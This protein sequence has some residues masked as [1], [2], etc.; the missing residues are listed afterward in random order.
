MKDG[1]IMGRWKHRLKKAV[2]FLMSAVIIAGSAGSP[3]LLSVQAEDIASEDI[4][5]EGIALQDS[6]GLADKNT[7]DSGEDLVSDEATAEDESP[8]KEISDFED[9]DF[10]AGS[11]ENTVEEQTAN[12]V[13]EEELI[14][15]KTLSFE[16]LPDNDELLSAY[17][18]QLSCGETDTEIFTYGIVGDKKLTDTNEKKLYRELKASIEKIANGSRSST[19]IT[20]DGLS[21]NVSGWE[22]SVRTVLSY[23]LMDCP[24]DL[25]WFD[26]NSAMVSVSRYNSAIRAITFSFLVAEEYQGSSAYTTN[27]AKMN[28]ARNAVTNAKAIVKKH[29]AESDRN[30][31]T[32]YCREIC[33]LVS[34]NISAA[35]GNAAYGN[36]WQL[37]WVFDK[38]KRTNVVCEGYAKAFQYLCDLSDFNNNTVCYTVT[39]VMSD[40]M[41]SA[42]HMWNIV[43][44]NGA[45]YL[46]DVTNCDSGGVGSDGSLF[47]AA[48]ESGAVN[49]G[50]TFV[51]SKGHS[52]KYTY[53]SESKTLLGQEILKLAAANTNKTG[54]LV[55]LS[56]NGQNLK[57][58]TT[59]KVTVNKKYS[60][61][62][63]VTD[64]AGKVLTGKAGKIT[65]STS[66]KKLATV[67]SSGKVSVGKKAG[68][69]TITAKTSNGKTAKVK[70]KASK[71]AV[72]VTK[73]KIT[74]SKTMS[75]KTA[76]AQTLKAAVTPASAANQKV[77]WKSSNKKIA[78][79]NSKGKVTA[80]K[81]G[82]VTITATAKDGSKKKA[83][84]KIKIKK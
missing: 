45:N 10:E 60:L 57:N 33:N 4:T 73:I 63:V 42:N 9:E 47:L 6:D 37:I 49:K 48:P 71:A 82:T 68:T 43:T 72:K 36:P 83:A 76:K 19:V 77:T 21:I 13:T 46:V 39:G 34:Y 2:V 35:Y 51:N 58:N 38:N 44:L 56:L 3:A 54:A 75:L 26:K 11:E 55:T 17:I 69:V 67:S 84:I 25:Y 53:N 32:S 30:K 20:V 5:A 78:T 66:N 52:V 79:V 41:N 40:G 61:K 50:Y 81:T 70:L 16:A 1:D 18:D 14:E 74:G 7:E 28:A 15:K 24:Y 64:T 62:A 12:A 59:L 31:L 29:A 80:K 27:A 22:K 8:V 65:W 23:L